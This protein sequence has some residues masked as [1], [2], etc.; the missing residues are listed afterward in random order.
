VTSAHPN[1]SGDLAVER[2][3]FVPDL[4]D[5]FV[6]RDFGAEAVVWSPSAAAPTALDPIATV[7]LEV[8]DGVASIS[9][10]AVDVHEV[11]GVSIEDAQRQV[12]RIVERFSEAGLLSSSDPVS[13]AVEAEE[14]RDL[15][16]SPPTPCAEN[17][18][19]LGTVTL[20]LRFG[21]QPVRVACDSRRGAR[22]LA[23]A[24]ADHR[25]ETIEDA[26][27]GFVLTAP[28]GLRRDHRLEDRSGF[29]LSEGRGLDSGLH[30][31]ASHLT[32]FLPPEPGTVRI[33][34]RSIVAGDRTIVCLTPLLY[35][36]TIA[37]A[38]LDRSGVRLI[39]RLAL[40][41]EISSGRITNPPIPWPALEALRPGPAHFGTGGTRVADVVMVLTGAGSPPPT[42]A[43]V[44]AGIGASGLHGS[45]ADLLDAG[46]RLVDN[47]ELCSSS[48]ESFAA[49]LTEFAAPGS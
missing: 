42:P 8:I 27:L 47:A 7:M 39:D 46:A 41:V 13:S 10:L 1:T 31:L 18:S 49:L 37:E 9:D 44:A 12:A 48:P 26:P 17:A 20:N 14:A 5:D 4:R 25:D 24:L 21:A 11:V 43:T 6:R 23:D 22:R 19:R 29:V 36:P 33:Q 2:L 15:F 3:A 16:L 45:F 30:A 40:D 35:V 32:A 28:Q 38:D 34:A